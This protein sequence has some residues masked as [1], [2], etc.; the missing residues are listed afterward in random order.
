[1][2]SPVYAL[3]WEQWRQVRLIIV[4]GV[5]MTYAAAWALHYSMVASLGSDL[6]GRGLGPE[7][8]FDEWAGSS[9]GLAAITLIL[10]GAAL[11]FSHSSPRNLRMGLPARILNLPVPTVQLAVVQ[12]GFRF[13]VM[14][15]TALLIG[16]ALSAINTEY[17]TVV[18][19]FA[20]VAVLG[21]AY[22]SAIA[23]TIGIV[24]PV[25][26]SV[27]IVVTTGPAL[28]VTA[29]LLSVGFTEG[30]GA[31][32]AV[33]AVVLAALFAVSFD[34][35]ARIRSVPAGERLLRPRAHV[36]LLRRP[37]PG[38]V[39][40]EGFRVECR[41]LG[42]IAPSFAA[43]ALSLSAVEILLSG[44]SGFD[45]GLRYVEEMLF[46]LPCIS[47]FIVGM[48]LIA[49]DHR[50]G[51]SGVARYVW[52]RPA[53]VQQAVLDRMKAV[54]LSMAITWLVP[55]LLY[56]AV[57]L[58]GPFNHR[59]GPIEQFFF[60][61]L[62][63]AGA[64]LFAWLAVWTPYI[65]IAYWLYLGTYAGLQQYV[66][67]WKDD[68]VGVVLVPCIAVLAVFALFAREAWRRRLFDARVVVRAAV[69]CLVCS[70]ASY[71]WLNCLVREDG[72]GWDQP[73]YWLAAA[74]AGLVPMITLFA[75]GVLLDRIRHGALLRRLPARQTG[76]A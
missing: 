68:T 7:T 69:L 14:G 39:G 29:Y 58:F 56:V 20:A 49:R 50:D 22:A 46:I 70:A 31:T 60:V 66:F 24:S 10:V 16:L 30:P 64:F 40:I 17:L 11:L 12:A 36:P 44:L 75:H 61:A 51:V 13:A 52:T 43:A 33:Y 8:I 34:R 76:T 6:V 74:S 9:T 26:A 57:N 72:Q 3:V 67:G 47:G 37:R 2:R 4:A 71:W 54:A 1:M 28:A 65:L 63:Y 18:L 25:A 41:R 19:P 38:E 32:I 55:F 5:A 48:V 59:L 53:S 45:Y 73:A 23:L 62:S 21:Y 42:W 35:F 15:L 27:V